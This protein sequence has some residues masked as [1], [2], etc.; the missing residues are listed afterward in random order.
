MKSMPANDENLKE[1]M[2]HKNKTCNDYKMKLFDKY[3]NED[4]KN[5]INILDLECHL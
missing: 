2:K 4:N 5:Y 3:L 1:Y